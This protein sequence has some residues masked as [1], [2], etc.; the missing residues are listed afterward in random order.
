ME[1]NGQVRLKQRKISIRGKYGC[2]VPCCY[3][4]DEKVGICSLD[5]L[6]ATDSEKFSGSF[7]ISGC[8]FKIGKCPEVIAQF[9][10][11]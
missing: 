8:H 6:T 9:Q 1:C 2:L 7:V 11:L 10:E 5:S 3:G 4:T